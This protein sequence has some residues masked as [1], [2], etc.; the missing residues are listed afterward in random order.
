M[1][2]ISP[3]PGSA[4][5]PRLSRPEAP[6]P[7]VSDVQLRARRAK[8]RRIVAWVLGGATLLMCAGLVRFAIVSHSQPAAVEP[9][10][11]VAV[12][13]PSTPTA[14]APTPAPSVEPTAAAPTA[15]GENPANTTKKISAAHLSKAKHPAAKS[16]VARH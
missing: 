13:A 14:A 12:M 10:A 1:N 6:A 16:S 15:G 5:D 2:N 3:L 8:L 7:E 4:N 11:P 9:A